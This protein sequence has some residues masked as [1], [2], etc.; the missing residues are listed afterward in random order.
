[1]ELGNIKKLEVMTFHVLSVHRVNSNAEVVKVRVP[2]VVRGHL[3]VV[4]VLSRVK[5]VLLACI[6]I[7]KVETPVKNVQMVRL[8]MVQGL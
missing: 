4:G 8:L 3:P 1:M 5:T 2:I 7:P 6:P